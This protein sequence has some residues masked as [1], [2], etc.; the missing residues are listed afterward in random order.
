M[1]AATDSGSIG[2]MQNAYLDQ[3]KSIRFVFVKENAP[4]L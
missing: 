4:R 1:L 2:S 3:T